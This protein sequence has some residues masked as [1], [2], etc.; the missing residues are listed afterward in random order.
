MLRRYDPFAELFESW[1][2]LDHLFRRLSVTR[3]TPSMLSS[4]RLLPG[5]AGSIEFQPAVECYTKDKQLVLRAELPGI[6]PKAVEISVLGNT[7]TL[8]GEKKEER[9]VEEENV[10]IRETAEGR[11]ERAFELPEGVRKDQVKA[12]LQ[13]GVLEVVIPAPAIEAARKVPL[14]VLE[15]GKKTI[16]AA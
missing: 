16:R 5:V 2:D 7:L 12:T 4:R 13:N 6:D 1:K 9:R 3:E 11:F 14:E 10:Y 8:K 15:T